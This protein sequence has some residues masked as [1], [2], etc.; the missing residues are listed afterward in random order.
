M[1]LPLVSEYDSKKRQFKE[2]K[3]DNLTMPPMILSKCI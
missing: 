3:V 2:H 1:E